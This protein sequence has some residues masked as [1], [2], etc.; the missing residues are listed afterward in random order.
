MVC[1]GFL[2][3]LQSWHVTLHILWVIGFGG[4]REYPRLMTGS[5]GAHFPKL[6]SFLRTAEAMIHTLHTNHVGL[7]QMLFAT[8]VIALTPHL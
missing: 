2:G 3:Q 1:V 5:P 8:S 4:S 6:A 7:L